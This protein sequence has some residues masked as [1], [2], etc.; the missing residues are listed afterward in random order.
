MRAYLDALTN[1]Y[2]RRSR[3]RFWAGDRTPSTR[4]TRCWRRRPGGR[5][6]AA[7]DRRGDLAR[8]DRR[9]VGAPDRLAGGRRLPRGRRPGRRDGRVRDV[10][11][12]ACLRKAQ[13]LCGSGCR[14]AT[15]P[16]PPPTPRPWSPSA[17]SWPTRSTSRRWFGPRRG[18]AV[19]LRVMQVLTVNAR[20]AG[21]R[22]GG[23]ARH[24]GEQERRL[25]GVRGRPVTAGGLALSEG[26]YSL[27]TV[28]AED[29][30]G[31][32]GMSEGPSRATGCAA[33]RVGRSRHHGDPGAGRRGAG[34]GRHPRRAAGASGGRIW[35]SV[36]GSA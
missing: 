4:C 9:A 22:L 1:W 31:A 10:C 24:Q 18:R 2:V 32:A 11:S 34:P 25:V 23:P 36:T 33:P 13:R 20:A 15:S 29:S 6:A 7:A 8:P 28:V 3:D 5:A 19:R 30:S 35:T 21:P 26:E 14:S 12:A 17:R 16:S 27:E